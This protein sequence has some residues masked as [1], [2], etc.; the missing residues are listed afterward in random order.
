MKMGQMSQRYGLVATYVTRGTTFHARACDDHLKKKYIYALDVSSKFFY[1]NVK[2]PIGVLWTN[3]GELTTRVCPCIGK[4]D[5]GGWQIPTMP[6][7]LP[8]RG[9]VGHLID[10]RIKAPS[11]CYESTAAA[12][13]GC[14]TLS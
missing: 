4:L 14:C 1:L 6:L 10:R 2:S 9:V 13:A 5:E 8:G 12:A 11:Y 7:Q 3:K